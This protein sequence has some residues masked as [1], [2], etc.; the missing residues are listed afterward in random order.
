M[1]KRSSVLPQGYDDLL[2]QLKERIRSTQIA[3][4]L[5]VNRELA[6]LYWCIGQDILARQQQAG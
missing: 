5:Q 2:M 3:A 4:S 1:A 6:L